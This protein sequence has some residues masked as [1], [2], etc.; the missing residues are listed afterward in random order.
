MQRIVRR[1]SGVRPR[2]TTY[3]AQGAPRALRPDMNTEPYIKDRLLARRRLLLDR[4]LDELD[5]A[6]VALDTCDS[7]PVGRAAERYDAELLLRLGDA[8]SR[9]LQEVIDAIVRFEAGIYGQCVICAGEIG[10]LRLRA[11]PAVATCGACA[12]DAEG[13][14]S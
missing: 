14:A 11:L 3:A 12:T 1:R 5:R 10:A 6:D 8:D 7:E 9:A 4:Y 2:K 13:R